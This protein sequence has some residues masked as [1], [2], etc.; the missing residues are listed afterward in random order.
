MN[1]IRN[2]TF[3]ASILLYLLGLCVTTTQ[4]GQELSYSQIGKLYLQS[5]E[6]LAPKPKKIGE[7]TALKSDVSLSDR[8][9]RAAVFHSFSSKDDT[10]LEKVVYSPLET[11]VQDLNLF[12]Y[13]SKDQKARNNSLFSKIN[14]TITIFGEAVLTKKLA[15]PLSSIDQLDKNQAFVKLLLHDRQLCNDLEDALNILKESQSD[16][17]SFWTE[18]NQL[19]KE[20]IDELFFAN[21]SFFK[22]LNKNSIIQGS[23]ISLRWKQFMVG[24]SLASVPV[25]ALVALF[26]AAAGKTLANTKPQRNPIFMVTAASVPFL[27]VMGYYQK[28]HNKEQSDQLNYLRKKLT[29]AARLVDTFDSFYDILKNNSIAMNALTN[30]KAITEQ[31]RSND[32]NTLLALLRTNT[33]KGDPS[34]FSRM[35]RIPAAYYLMQ[36]NKAEFATLMKFVGEVD[37]YLSIVKLY[38]KHHGTKNHYSFATYVDKSEP[39]IN[40]KQ[41]WNPMLNAHIAVANSL[42]FNVNGKARIAVVTGSNSAGKSTI[43]INGLTNSLWLAQTLG[44]TSADQLTMTP[45]ACIATSIKVRESLLAG[46]SH[47]VAQTR[48]AAS[49]IDLVKNLPLDQKAFMAIDELFDGTTPAIGSKALHDFGKSLVKYKNLIAVICTQYQKDP[50]FLEQETN[51]ICK[52]YKVDVV[53][54]DDNTITRPYLVQEGVSKINIGVELLQEL[55]ADDAGNKISDQEPNIDD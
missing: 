8:E 14:N 53:K 28:R 39:Y 13:K 46:A 27:A 31:Q 55:L 52:N 38:K 49:L 48:Q 36:E 33:F 37:A 30:A 32:F 6:S 10:Q 1:P 18:T 26:W 40:I 42:E 12:F 44:I 3:A 45:F 5:F 19:E 47:F 21:D 34:F 9:L 15:N 17:L 2:I 25:A 35:S 43:M 29:C 11:V 24:F 7:P 41:F 50:T 22:N 20:S 23:A 51:G 16:L 54:N 4:P